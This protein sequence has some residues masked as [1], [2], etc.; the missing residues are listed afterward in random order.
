MVTYGMFEAPCC[1]GH[2]VSRHRDIDNTLD[3]AVFSCGRWRQRP[4]SS[5]HSAI[6][7]SMPVA[8]DCGTYILVLVQSTSLHPFRQVLLPPRLQLKTIIRPPLGMLA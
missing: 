1:L 4:L 8:A 5:Q 6:R 7:Y 3:L 2:C